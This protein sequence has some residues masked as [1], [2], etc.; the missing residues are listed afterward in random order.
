METENGFFMDIG[1]QRVHYKK[2]IEAQFKGYYGKMLN[3]YPDDFFFFFPYTNQA[4]ALLSGI[5]T[6]YF[7]RNF[8]CAAILTRSLLDCV[9]SWIYVTQVT[10]DDYKDFLDEFMKSGEITKVTKK[11]NKRTR[12]T[13]Q[14]LTDTFKKCRGIDLSNSYKQLS[15]MVHPSIHHFHA[16]T[17]PTPDLESDACI[18]ITSGENTE[19]PQHLYDELKDIVHLCMSH[20]VILWD[21]RGG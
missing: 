13:G 11:G 4:L 20:V 14:D 3:I 16:N 6:A 12:V 10:Q 8:L 1:N 18:A 9:M 17:R 5:E 15:K 7:G 2:V 21:S 19:Y